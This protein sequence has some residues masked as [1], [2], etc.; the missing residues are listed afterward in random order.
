M[1]KVRMQMRLSS[2]AVLSLVALCF[3]AYFPA[4][5]VAQSEAALASEPA[6]YRDAVDGAIAEYEARN[7][8][9]A[10]A[11]FAKAHALYANARTL[12]GQ[13]MAEFELR[14]YGDAISFLEQALDSSEKPLEGELR[15]E[16]EA[17]LARAKTF[18]ARFELSIEPDVATVVVDGVPMELRGQGS[19]VLKVGD[20]VLEFRAPGYTSEKRELKVN[21]GEEKALNIVLPKQVDLSTN[22]QA[23]EPAETSR[24]YKSPWLWTGV[25]IVVAGVAVGTAFAVKGDGSSDADPYGGGSGVV[26]NGP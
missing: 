26:L 25:A 18:V 23:S 13:G 3:H 10:R 16:T 20:H 24:W 17:L 9:E 12:R 11:L 19:L 5:T 4:L 21:G 8:A 14:N 22:T 7:F 15:Q 2:L 1:S 6:G